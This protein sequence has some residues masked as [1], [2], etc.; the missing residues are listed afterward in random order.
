MTG[1][2]IDRAS[3]ADSRVAAGQFPSSAARQAF[4]T[5][6][7]RTT[8]LPMFEIRTATNSSTNLYNAENSQRAGW[9]GLCISRSVQYTWRFARSPMYARFKAV[10]EIHSPFQPAEHAIA[11]RSSYA[12]YGVIESCPIPNRVND[13]VRTVDAHQMCAYHVA[14][15]Q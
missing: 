6:T 5:T 15:P 14:L 7:V 4:V 9:N 11:A 13:L 1:I 8:T 2:K 10:R 3:E 12:K